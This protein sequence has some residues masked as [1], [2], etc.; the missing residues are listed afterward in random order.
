[1][2]FLPALGLFYIII[3]RKG[4]VGFGTRS[5]L[6]M[7]LAHCVK[8]FERKWAPSD[9][10]FKMKISGLVDNFNKIPAMLCRVTQHLKSKW[11]IYKESK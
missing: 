2:D 8:C 4:S 11:H 6:K 9:S 3:I 7:V 5:R 10:N 1:M